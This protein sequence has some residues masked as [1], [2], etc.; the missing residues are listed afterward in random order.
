MNRPD[1]N[2]KSRFGMAKPGIHGIPPVA[3]LHCG[4]GM[5]DGVQKYGLTN[6][7]E[8]SVSAAIYY[9]AAFRHLASWWDGEQVAS[10]FGVHHLGHVM[11]CCAILLDAEAG[12][13]MVDD[14]PAIPGTFAAA[15]KAMTREMLP[16]LS[17]PELC[18]DE[19]CDHHGTPHLCVTVAEM[20]Q[21]RIAAAQTAI[22]EV[23]DRA[24]TLRA[25]AQKGGL[26]DPAMEKTHEIVGVV[27]AFVDEEGG[28]R[29]AR[30]KYVTGWLDRNGF[31][32]V[33]QIGSIRDQAALYD[34]IDRY[35]EA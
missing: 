10:D 33:R 6:W 32:R 1:S 29:E 8:N 13:N 34:H 25:P 24:L 5:E 16:E 26:L 22:A 19:G 7:R 17:E 20:T 11:A 23:A 21:E 4:R 9:N 12:G 30:Q 28:K 14:R 15:V 31:D 18:E 35:V 27:R 3:L 2:P